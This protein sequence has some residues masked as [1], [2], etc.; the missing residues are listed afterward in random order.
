MDYYYDRSNWLMNENLLTTRDVEPLEYLMHMNKSFLFAPTSGRASYSTN[1]FS[2]VG[3]ALAGL[4]N[5]T[6]WVELDQNALAWGSQRF[7]DDQTLFPDRGPC[8]K[9]ARIAHQYSSNNTAVDKSF[10]D[11]DPHS[12]INS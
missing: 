7:H 4:F 1:G 9:D 11:L 12:C 8:A 5:H 3:L 6:D 10:F 2:L